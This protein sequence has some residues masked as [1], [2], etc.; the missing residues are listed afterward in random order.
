MDTLAIAI[1]IASTH[2]AR[3][4]LGRYQRWSHDNSPPPRLF[5]VPTT[6][7]K[8]IKAHA[9]ESVRVALIGNKADLR[10]CPDAGTV[11]TDPKLATVYAEKFGASRRPLPPLPRLLLPVVVCWA[12]CGA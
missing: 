4:H 12:R 10:S 9:S 11:C 5:R 3:A 6:R 2:C 1:A 7:I 8:N